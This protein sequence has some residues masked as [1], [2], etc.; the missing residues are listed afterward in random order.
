MS[1]DLRNELKTGEYDL[2]KYLVSTLSTDSYGLKKE[3]RGYRSTTVKLSV[4]L[5][6]LY[7]F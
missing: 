1:N 7:N 3:E 5:S 6:S 2:F 4:G